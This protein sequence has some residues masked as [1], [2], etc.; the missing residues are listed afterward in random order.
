ML[1]NSH[2]RFWNSGERGDSLSDCNQLT[3]GIACD[4]GVHRPLNRLVQDGVGHAPLG[5]LNG[6]L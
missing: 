3:P 4:F 5:Q 1:G 6:A 2:V